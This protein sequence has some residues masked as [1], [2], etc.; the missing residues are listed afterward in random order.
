MRYVA[1]IIII[2]Y[3]IFFTIIFSPLLT[4]N[5]LADNYNVNGTFNMTG[6]TESE[7]EPSIFSV[8]GAWFWTA[9]RFFCLALFGIGVPDLP[10]YIQLPFSLWQL[11]VSSVTVL[12]IISIF[13]E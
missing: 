1:F 10:I 12:A 9:F 2:L 8:I 11:F 4:Q 6:F 5:P 13:T 3:W 7:I